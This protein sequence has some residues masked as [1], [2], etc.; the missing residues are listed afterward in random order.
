MEKILFI[1][2]EPEYI[3]PY[4][5]ELEKTF[6]V[7]FC[8]SAMESIQWIRQDD[9]FRAVVLDIQM[10]APKDLSPS[11]TNNGVDTGLWVLREVYNIIVERPLPVIILTN[12]RS[13]AVE[14]SVHKM[15][16]PEQMIEIHQKINTSNKKLPRLV[17]AILHRWPKSD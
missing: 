11:S 10:P 7:V 17:D 16:F 4:L 1:D 5:D 12:R 3:D 8:Q 14:V 6:R 15:G 13:D 2:D 9:T